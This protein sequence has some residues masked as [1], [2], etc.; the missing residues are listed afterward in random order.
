MPSP[1][2]TTCSAQQHSSAQPRPQSVTGTAWIPVDSICGHSLLQAWCSHLAKQS[3][4]ETETAFTEAGEGRSG[5]MGSGSPSQ[6]RL[7]ALRLVQPHTC[8]SH[9]LNGAAQLAAP[10][11]RSDSILA[12]ASSARRAKASLPSSVPGGKLP[13]EL[14]AAYLSS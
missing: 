3:S 14:T 9:S 6:L 8:A 13:Q 7:P 12:K 11:P 10:K 2:S 1:T 4:Q 5:T